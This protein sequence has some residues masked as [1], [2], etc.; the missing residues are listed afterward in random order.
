[1]PNN[2]TSGIHPNIHQ[3]FKIL[4]EQDLDKIHAA[5]MRILEKTGIRF[6]SPQAIS[7][8]A[9]AGAEIN[10]SQVRIPAKIVEKAIQT[11]PSKVTLYARDPQKNLY[12]GQGCIHFSSGF[13]ATWVRDLDTGLVRDANL[14]DLVTFTRLAE[15]LKLVHMVLFAVVPQDVPS[16]LRDVICTAEVL[17]NTTKHIQLSLESSET[18]DEVLNIAR[19]FVGKGDPLPISAG[20]VPNS[21]LHYTEDVSTKFIRLARENVPC[22]IVTGC[23]AG[24]TGP[25]TLAGL[26][27]Q[28]TAE[29]LAGTVLHQLANPGAPLIYGTFS[30]GFDMR[31]TKLA[32]GG[33]EISLITCATQQLCE[34]YQIP[35][36]YATGGVTDSPVSDIQ[37]GI[38]KTFGVLSAAMAGVDVIHD[39]AS[40][41]L[42]AGMVSSL[43]QLIIDHDMCASIK[44]FLEG[45]PVSSR[46]LA[47][48][49][50]SST[51]PGGNYM[52]SDHTLTE[53]RKSL[54]ITPIR[55]RNLDPV[56]TSEPGSYLLV[57]ANKQ[58]KK[59]LDTFQPKPIAA[60]QLTEMDQIIEEARLL[61]NKHTGG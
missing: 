47:E 18:L 34:R 45:I 21:P 7:L 6:D 31:Y 49:L 41:L 9:N 13:G 46:T 52:L 1:M 40:G 27:V 54:F 37:T 10:G 59:I 43:G 36:G 57:N 2:R 3:N 17:K 42:G 50:I 30:G 22:L 35:M 25:V 16:R 61:I 14:Q 11:A 12:L 15:A 23:M 44:Y 55:A 5:A 28:Q 8:L 29:F 51:G 24:A 39:A 32:L 38:E 19:T 56:N 33:P 60:Q 26:L 53:F 20:G 48:E 58:A 4:S